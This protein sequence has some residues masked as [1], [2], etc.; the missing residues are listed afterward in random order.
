MKKSDVRRVARS[1]SRKALAKA[2]E[3]LE[4]AK[5]DMGAERWNAAG[6][7]AIHSAIASADAGLIATAGLRSA[8]QD[9]GAAV[10]LLEA[11]V[12]EFT[13]AQRRQ[14]AGALRLKN[15]VAYEQRLLRQDEARTLVDHATRLARWAERIVARIGE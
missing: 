3:F 15:A 4:A 12:P 13:G 5:A 11:Q 1:E 10:A 14:L 8:S 7:A 2:S 9:H 6:L